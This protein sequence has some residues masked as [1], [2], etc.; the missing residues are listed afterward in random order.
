MFF[1]VANGTAAHAVSVSRLRSCSVRGFEV[2]TAFF[3]APHRKMSNGVR[4]D[5]L[6]GCST[7]SVF[8]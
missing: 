1:I 6:G 4:S 3:R 5:D 8:Q 2:Y 7:F